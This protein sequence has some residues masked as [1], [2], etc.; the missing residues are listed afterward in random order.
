MELKVETNCPLDGFK[1]CRQLQCAWFTKI[2]GVNPQTNREIE[3]WGCAI[4]WLPI[5][6][7]ETANHVRMASHATDS[8][9]NEI[10]RRMD[11]VAEQPMAIE[12]PPLGP[13]LPRG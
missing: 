10:V 4:A 13:V 3:N 1:P 8:M 5:L 12:G 9:R 2:N 6:S 7:I 11:G